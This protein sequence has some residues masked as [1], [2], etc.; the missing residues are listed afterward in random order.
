MP[1]IA[2]CVLDGEGVRGLEA[3]RDALV[4]DVP[5][6]SSGLVLRDSFARTASHFG[7]PARLHVGIGTRE[8][9][10]R[11][12]APAARG[13]HGCDGCRMGADPATAVADGR[14]EQHETPAVWVGH[15]SAL[16][17]PSAFNSSIMLLALA[18][19]TPLH[20]DRKCGR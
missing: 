20:T 17:S 7:V 18:Q 16:P 4:P 13:Q 11:P 5:S 14:G 19:P 2:V 10:P 3:L 1:A 9:L 15:V 6:E 12:R 8:A